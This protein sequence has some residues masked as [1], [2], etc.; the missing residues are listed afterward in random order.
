VPFPLFALAAFLQV[1][2]PASAAAPADTGWR[3]DTDVAVPMRDGVVLRA[4][5]YRPRTGGPFPVLVY[6]TPYGKNDVV[7]DYTTVQRAVAR[8]YAVVVQDVRG[9]YASAG[10]FNAYRQEGQDG[11]DTIEWAAVQPWSNGAIGTFGL[12][13][14]GAVQWLAAMESPPHL[15]AMVPAMTF[16]SPR[17]FF[18]SGGAWDLS[19]AAWTSL[20]IAPD[21]RARRGLAG[22]RTYAEAREAWKRDGVRIVE[23]RPLLALPDFREVAPWYYDWMHHEPSDAWWDWAE[24]TGRYGRTRAAV[25]NLS[26]WHDEAYGPHGATRNHMGLVESRG[27]AA[28]A[29]TARSALVIGPWVHGVDA[30]ARTRSG[31]REFGAAAAIDYDEVVLRWMDR[32]VRGIDNGVD[33]EPAVR[34]FVMG[35]SRWRTGERWP[36][37]EL[38]PDTL[39]FAA[40]GRLARTAPTAGAEAASSFVSDP[41]DPVRDP[42]D[43]AYGAHDFRA[44]ATRR[45]LLTFETEPFATPVEVIGDIVAEVQLETDARDVDVYVRLLDVAPDGTAYNLMSPGLELQRASYREPEKGRQLLE[46]G[47][48]YQLR[49]G[50]MITANEF[51]AGHRL[52]VHIMGAF[53]PHFSLNPQTGESERTSAALQSA[54]ITIRHGATHPSRLILPVMREP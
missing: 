46:P 41:R 34:V 51:Q 8:G 16:A 5:T 27:G 31:A 9:R 26:G 29:S 44:L 24:L 14:P 1:A 47:R 13:Y 10:E 33:R 48:T 18:Y 6:R 36:L 11:Y 28:G 19:W 35:A 25:L 49:I 39:W 20:N 2:A 43:A 37:P 50:S 7:A 42:F 22:P 53:L 3:V 17:Q 12:S 45:D 32:Y 4:N 21:V 15:K 23:Q 38:R 30:T 40:G 52:R 54:R